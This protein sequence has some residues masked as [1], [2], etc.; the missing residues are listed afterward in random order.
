[1]ADETTP[2]ATP[3]IPDVAGLVDLPTLAAHLGVT[4]AAVRNALARGVTWLPAP[5]GQLHG[6]VWRL[7][8]LATIDEDR[9]KPGRPKRST[10]APAPTSEATP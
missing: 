9:P 2:T 4:P 5:A 10:P 8:D 1:M 6:Y 7:D 3:A